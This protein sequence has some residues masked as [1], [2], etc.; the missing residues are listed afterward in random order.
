[1]RFLNID[2]FLFR[3]FPILM[4]M[5]R[6]RR[7]IGSVSVRVPHTYGDVPNGVWVAQGIIYNSA[8]MCLTGV[9]FG[10]ILP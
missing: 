7:G 8:G 9:C 1:M 4:G 5:Y 10:T 3:E 2:F 6:N